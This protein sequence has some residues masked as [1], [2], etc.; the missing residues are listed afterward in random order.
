MSQFGSFLQVGVKIKNLWNHHLET[1]V[2]SCDR[3]KGGFFFA[4]PADASPSCLSKKKLSRQPCLRSCVGEAFHEI[5]VK[6][7]FTQRIF[8]GNFQW[9]KHIFNWYTMISHLY[10]SMNRCIFSIF[11]IMKNIHIKCLACLQLWNRSRKGIWKMSVCASLEAWNFLGPRGPL[12]QIAL[13]FWTVHPVNRSMWEADCRK[14][15]V[16][17]GISETVGEVHISW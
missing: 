9:T 16:T 3:L 1:V 5:P 10:L 7:H 13:E 6:C 2:L 12:S 15:G 8:W 11:Q 4:S 17:L 14:E